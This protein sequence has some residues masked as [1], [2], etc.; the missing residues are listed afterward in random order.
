MFI[1]V[2]HVVWVPVTIVWR[3]PEVEETVSRCGG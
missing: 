1:D 3:I 2:G